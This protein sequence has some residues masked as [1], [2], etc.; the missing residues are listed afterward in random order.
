VQSLRTTLTLGVKG[1]AIYLLPHGCLALDACS[2]FLHQVLGL[3]LEH[4]TADWPLQLLCL[5]GVAVV[6]CCTPF[7][8]ALQAP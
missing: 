6:F 1:I 2:D 7:K 5:S 4:V 3:R 8:K